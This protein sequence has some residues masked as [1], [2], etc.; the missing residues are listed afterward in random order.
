MAGMSDEAREYVDVL[1]NVS[2]ARISA[3][4]EIYKQAYKDKEWRTLYTAFVDIRGSIETL[5]ETT[6]RIMAYGPDSVGET[7][8]LLL[9]SAIEPLGMP[10]EE[11]ERLIEKINPEATIEYLRRFSNELEDKLPPEP[12]S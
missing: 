3:D 6:A 2:T 1:V 11:Y 5:V 12:P 4:C 8:N 9:S 10:D 7:I